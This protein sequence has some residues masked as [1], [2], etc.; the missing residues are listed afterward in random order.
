[1]GSDEPVRSF[2]S[3]ALV[4]ELLLIDPFVL[5]PGRR[6]FDAGISA[7][8]RLQEVNPTTTGVLIATYRPEVS[9]GGCREGDEDGW[10]FPVPGCRWPYLG[11][12]G[13]GARLADRAHPPSRP[14][15]TSGSVPA[16]Q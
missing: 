10:R 16:R 14:P 15:R 11:R 3:V 13:G 2:M 5:G 8:L 9:G 7:S 6:L 4:D 1:L 12:R